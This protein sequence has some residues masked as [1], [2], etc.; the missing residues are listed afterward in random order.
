M[1]VPAR[2]PATYEDLCALPENL[3]G[4]IIDGELY[5]SPRP[6]SRHAKVSSVLGMDLGGPFQRGRGGP[7]GWWILDEP[8]LHFGNDVL[9]PDLAGWK[10]ERMPRIPDAPFIELA[11]N[12][13][14]EVLSPSTAKLDLVRKL[15]RYARASVEHAWVI[16]PIHRTL[17]VFRQE[18]ERWV[19]VAAFVGDDK[20]RAEPFDAVELE[21]GALWLEEAPPPSPDSE[22]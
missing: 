3:V 13:I 9:V 8:E 17:E 6:A 12:W 10:V 21:L 7:G 14:C 2:K 11:P 15:P 4:E 16:D 18:H 20:V 19:L 5:T 22:R 1:R